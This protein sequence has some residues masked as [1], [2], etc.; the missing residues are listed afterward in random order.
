MMELE[1]ERMASRKRKRKRQKEVPENFSQRSS[2]ST[3]DTASDPEITLVN[4]VSRSDGEEALRSQ[5]KEPAPG[6]TGP[7][8]TNTAGQEGSSRQVELSAQS[9]KGHPIAVTADEN[10]EGDG[11]DDLTT[12]EDHSQLSLQTSAFDSQDQE[13]PT[14][15]NPNLNPKTTSAANC[16]STG[17]AKSNRRSRIDRRKE[18]YRAA[19][20]F[21]DDEWAFYRPISAGNGH[22]EVEV[23]L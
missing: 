14:L 9:P 19:R 23:E 3:D 5:T 6:Q 17:A 20:S 2:Q 7:D 16:T 12:R 18:A 22:T 15:H 8:S 13:S 10:D 1:G 4:A 11:S 21:D